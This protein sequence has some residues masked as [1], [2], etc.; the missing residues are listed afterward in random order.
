LA[1]FG[2]IFEPN[3]RPFAVDHATNSW[4]I[5]RWDDAVLDGFSNGLHPN[6]YK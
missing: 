1:V 2:V 4:P 3:F 6:S 5:F